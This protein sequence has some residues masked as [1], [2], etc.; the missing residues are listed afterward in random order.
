MHWEK[1]ILRY[2]DTHYMETWILPIEFLDMVVYGIAY[3]NSN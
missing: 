1:N 3:G 2:L